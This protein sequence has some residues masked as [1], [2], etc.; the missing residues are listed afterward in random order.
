MAN[1][2]DWEQI[3]NTL[4]NTLKEEAVNYVAGHAEET[5]VLGVE[6]VKAV[7][8][9][10]LIDAIPIPEINSGLS[11]SQLAEVEKVLAR[12][13][14]LAQLI[15]KAEIE[16]SQRIAKLKLD[17]LMV[18]SKIGMSLLSVGVGVLTTL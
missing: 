14:Q 1:Q 3:K 8:Q 13:D 17:A 10:A 7:L 18:A 4:L 9:S 2:V 15:S 5:A 11:D 6:T 12:R 16:N